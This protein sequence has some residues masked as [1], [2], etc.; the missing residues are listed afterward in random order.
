MELV[1]HTIRK[2]DNTQK[3]SSIGIFIRAEEENRKKKNIE[4]NSHPRNRQIRKARKKI[5]KLTTRYQQDD[6]L[7]KNRFLRRD[8]SR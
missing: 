5:K 4:A 6:S 8:E 7:K 1:F 2:G 3:K